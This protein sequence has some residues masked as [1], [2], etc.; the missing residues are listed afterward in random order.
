MNFLAILKAILKFL[1]ETS[2]CTFLTGQSWSIEMHTTICQHC[3][4][5]SVDSVNG[6]WELKQKWTSVIYVIYLWAIWG[7][8]MSHPDVI[9][10][11]TAAWFS[12]LI[13]IP[14]AAQ[15]QTCYLTQGSF[16]FLDLLV[17]E[18]SFRMKSG[19]FL[20]EPNWSYLKES[21]S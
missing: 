11:C 12:V 3:A 6:T 2:C 14:R 5:L 20:L 15:F 9:C 13:R 8:L 16:P 10:C 7:S 4:L 21:H 19:L 18:G 1:C 17:A